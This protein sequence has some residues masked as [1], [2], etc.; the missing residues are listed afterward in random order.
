MRQHAQIVVSPLNPDELPVFA[1]QGRGIDGPGVGGGIAGLQ[2]LQALHIAQ[3][4]CAQVTDGL[5]Q[6]LF[7]PLLKLCCFVAASQPDQCD[8]HR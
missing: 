4:R 1:Q 5:H 2:R 3:Q 7:Q 6:A 8:Q